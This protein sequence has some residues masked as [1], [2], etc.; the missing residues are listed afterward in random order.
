LGSFGAK[1]R[2]AVPELLKAGHD[3]EKDVREAAAGALIRIDPSV[4]AE[5]KLPPPPGPA[6]DAG[7]GSV[8]LTMRGPSS[9]ALDMYKAIAGVELV[10]KS[11]EPIPGLINVRTT[12]PLSPKEAME[13]LEKALLDQCG[14]VL[15]HVDEKHVAVKMR[16][17][18]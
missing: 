1:A 5:A 8:T 17:Q 11:Q 6:S 4:A 2:S 10:M 14:I 12:R 9:M 15:E 16:R 18:K 3:S 13:F 7:A